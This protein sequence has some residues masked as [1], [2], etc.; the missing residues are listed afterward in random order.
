M[1]VTFKDILQKLPLRRVLGR[2]RRYL[3]A[4]NQ[5]AKSA[6]EIFTAVY[7]NNIWGGSKGQFFSGIHY[8]GDAYGATIR[9]YMEEHQITRVLDCGCGDFNIGGQIASACRSYTG[10][11]VVP[12][13]VE[14]NRRLF[15][16]PTINFA[17]LD[18]VSDP[19]PDADLC[20]VLQTFQHLTNRD[21]LKFL[22]KARKFPHLIVSEQQPWRPIRFN[23]DQ[24]RG[25]GLR[26]N[27]GSGVY[28][29]QPPFNVKTLELLFE[30]EATMPFF[31]SDVDWGAIR[32][33]RVNL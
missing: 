9:R 12:S 4:H 16:S 11:D 2:A 20:L 5:H 13:L 7:E 25:G 15:D 33:F 8:G 23:S 28:L 10:V 1:S 18:I 30:A 24:P 27:Q 29:E 19:L 6:K 31:A 32:T 22:A 17:C 26:L 21:I 14:R 3:A